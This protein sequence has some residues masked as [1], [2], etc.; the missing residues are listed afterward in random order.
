MNARG[1]GRVSYCVEV[2]AAVASREAIVE[3]SCSIEKC[4]ELSIRLV[5]VGGRSPCPRDRHDCSDSCIDHRID[6][7]HQSP[8]YLQICERFR[9]AI[10]AGHL[11]PGDRAPALRGGHVRIV[12]AAGIGDAL[13]VC[14]RCSGGGVWT[15]D[16]RSMCPDFE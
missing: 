16:T 7:Q 15:A 12:V 6:R 14:A 2:F 3:E 9:S 4:Q 11:R 8:I 5:H 1:A 13:V 10:A